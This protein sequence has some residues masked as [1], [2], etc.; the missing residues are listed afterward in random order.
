MIANTDFAKRNEVTDKESI[1]RTIGTSD[2]SW[3]LVA[4]LVAIPVLVLI[5]ALSQR[6]WY[7]TGDLAQAELRMRSLPRHPPLVGAA[8]RIIDKDGR[9][10]NHPGPLMFWATWPLYALLGRSS[11]AFEAATA[12]VNLFWL[13][14]SVWLVTRRAGAGVCAWYG[15]TAL[16]LI[17]GYGLDALSQPWNPWV[18]L[19]P[20][21]VLLLATWSTLEGDRWAWVIAV[22][23]ACYSLQSHVGYLPLA[24]PLAGVNLVWP[25]RRGLRARR[26]ATAADVPST[27]Q[28]S[29]GWAVPLLASV[30]VAL[31]AWSGPF[32]EVVTNHP[33]NVQKLIANFANPSDAPIGLRIAV[34]IVLQ[35]ANPL[36]AWVWGGSAVNGS[37]VPGLLFLTAWAV[38]AMLVAVRRA[39][40]S[41]TRLNAVVAV[42]TLLAVVAVSCI[43]GPL[44]LYVF[45]WIVAIVALQAFT[46]GWGVATLLPR[47]APAVNSH[48]AG[49]AAVTLLVLSAVMSVRLARQEIPYV[50][51]WQSEQVLASKVTAQLDP[52]R[53]YLV[54]W[55]DP[56]YLGGLGFGL[57]LELER[58]G[59]TVGGE[60][61]F[62]AAI[63]PRRVMCPGNYN[64]VLT[65]VTGA[66]NTATY[67][68]KS[69]YRKLASVDLR[70]D[71]AAWDEQYGQL[72]DL[73]ARHG[74]PTTADAL[75]RRFRL[76]LFT[77]GLPKDAV[78]LIAKL[79]LDG[80]PSAVFVQ[81]PAPAEPPVAHTPLNEPCWK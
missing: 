55:D 2:H 6:T 75:E 26:T 50:E 30:V 40:L 61:Q 14:L 4:L 63:E 44:Y 21:T 10:G 7:P 70:K 13:S 12:I 80:V 16:I 22:A 27:R 1:R 71:P 42:V 17:G 51:S 74:R 57:I 28:T 25:V 38:V 76:L 29:S 36:G 32:W 39:N 49:L 77:P 54:R 73:L 15:I 11:W 66:R 72:V 20:F 34:K 35:A 52:K 41:L 81:D 46:L 45:R 37:A 31:L 58:R 53:R 60:P 69:G 62:D 3:L 68:Q 47:T 56:T 43:F 24:V 64:A 48:L 5:V 65:V 79:V 19:L 9:Q 67:E 59:F 23:A 33:N 18:A 78:D 8:G